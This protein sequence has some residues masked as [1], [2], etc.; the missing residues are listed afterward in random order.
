MS[1]ASHIVDNA[2]ENKSRSLTPQQ[3]QALAT[4]KNISVT[5]GAGSGK[6]TILVER[7]LKII[8]NEGVDVRRVLAITFTE[9]AAA[10]MIERVA[11][12]I[13]ERMSGA[14]SDKERAKLLGLRERLNAAQISTIHAFCAKILREFAVASGVDP[15][16]SMLNEL[17][18]NLLARE[19]ID[20]IFEQLD[21][22]TLE[23][24]YPMDEWL[25]LLRQVSPDLLRQML[26]TLIANRYEVQKLQQHLASFSDE[27]MVEKL[28]T[29]FFEALENRVKTGP[30]LAAVLPLAREILSAVIVRAELKEKG[31]QVFAL[32]DEIL[33]THE[34]N[35]SRSLLWQQ[36]IDVAQLLV[37]D[38]GAPFKMLTGLGKKAV[39]GNSYDA[40][41][42]LSTALH[43]LYQF[44]QQFGSTVPGRIDRLNFQALRKALLL[45]EQAEARYRE[46]KDERGLLDFDDL[47]LLT[48]QMLREHAEVR[49]ELR[50]RYRYIMVDE[51]QDT[52]ELQWEI[53]SLMGIFDGKLQADKFFVVGDPK[54]SIYGFRNADVRVFQRVK[55]TFAQQVEIP[56]NYPGNVVLQDSFRFLPS[57]NRFVNFL[58]SQLLGSDAENEFDV[59]YE[60]LDTQRAAAGDGQIEFAVLNDEELK[61]D[62]LTQEDYVAQRI[63]GLLGIPL[64]FRSEGDIPFK[65]GI[66][67]SPQ[68]IY[69]RVDGR[70]ELREILP[71]DIAILIPTRTHLID[72]ESKLRQYGIPFKTIGGVGFYRRQE[73][74]DVYH[75]LRFLDNPAD[76]LA[77][78]GLLRSPF[79]GISDAGL[80]Y[81][82]MEKGEHYHDKLNNIKNFDQYP[83]IDREP[84]KVF[85]KQLQRWQQ[86]RDRLSLSRLISEIFDD[87]FYRATLAANWNGEQ[88]L[89]NLDKLVEQ[90]RDFEQSGFMAL[91]DFIESLRETI[92]LDPR[93]G[94]AQIALE[95]ENTVKIMTIHQAKGLEFPVVFCP[96]LQRSPQGERHKL[97]F[98]A[99][100]GLAAK[101]RDPQNNYDERTPFLFQQIDFRRQ[102]KEIAELKRLFYVAVTRA[103]DRLFLVGAFKRNDLT[104]EN[105]LSWAS[106]KLKLAEAGEMS[107]NLSA[108][109]IAPAEN[110][111]VRVVRK[112]APVNFA[113]AARQDISPALQQLKNTLDAA[114]NNEI[115]PVFL[116]VHLRSVD[117]HPKGVTF[118]A[119]QLLTFQAD[120]KAYFLRYHRGFFESDYEFLTRYAEPDSLSLLKGKIVHKILE[121]GLPENDAAILAKLEE[122]FF[123]YEIFDP[124]EQ[125]DFQR[126]IP[127]LLKPF[128]TGDFAKKIFSAPDSK[129][130]IS[131][132][133]R[134]GDDFF[135]GTLDRVF[136]NENG[137]WEVVDYKT[138]N[139]TAKK[140]EEIGSKYLMQMK[141]YALLMAQLFPQQS[142][143][144]VALYFLKPQKTFQRIFSMPDIATI[145]REFADLM[146]QIKELYPFGA[147]LL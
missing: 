111:S 102:Q 115:T 103:R 88:L 78:A 147:K 140:V 121:D 41:L 20:D 144:C 146:A 83:E 138:N 3:Q 27:Q 11:R 4:D 132:T 35:A 72:L 145:R 56:E 61:A 60:H 124:K 80:F 85:R 82:A 15:D 113:S 98:D 67:T 7:Y 62:E 110:L 32:L 42:A 39:L 40:L 119:T 130:E 96:Y 84:L 112:I 38:K 114:T 21:Q 70:E 123:Q 116:P 139:I 104:G 129:T 22:R 33:I 122:A 54:Q 18:Q 125:A 19:S 64:T 49:N 58:F 90:V 25:E 46:K 107:E 128:I 79:A 16:F 26:S 52:N 135:T 12:M 120:P 6:T 31:Q 109:S 65:G 24:D 17:Q 29:E 141:A 37:T 63:C 1:N 87:S 73:I 99:D 134:L 59:S 77:M 34:S 13:R 118:S 105:C 50:N 126:E 9:K 55:S 76:D 131:L 8:I 101:I 23:S 51:F 94:E 66:N 28:Q 89:A 86:R 30:L 71:G 36:L 142:T 133:M 74:F 92:K 136:R 127:A 48:L 93:E 5:A 14:I 45:Y 97:R 57:L 117:D 91:S 53:I 106:D 69:Q 2:A 95:D 68:K 143:F 43:P 108:F 44:S 137:N 100:L 75:L 81:L 10:E 47:Q